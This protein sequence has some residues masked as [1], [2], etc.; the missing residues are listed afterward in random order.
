[1]ISASSRTRDATGSGRKSGCSTTSGARRATS[2]ARFARGEHEAGSKEQD[3]PPRLPPSSHSA[4]CRLL[5]PACSR[6]QPALAASAADI[7]H[8]H[9]RLRFAGG[10]DFGAIIAVAIEPALPDAAE[11]L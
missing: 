10:E 7:A 11:E 1:M 9:L 3:N 8:L 5:L 6:P 4:A 2:S